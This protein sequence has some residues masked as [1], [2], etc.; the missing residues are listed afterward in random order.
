MTP[1]KPTF[2]GLS[3]ERRLEW[4]G[5]VSLGAIWWW[6]PAADHDLVPPLSAITR[7]LFRLTLD[8]VLM[9]D[10]LTSLGRVLPGVAIALLISTLLALITLRFKSLGFAIG[11]ILELLRPVP[12][13]AWIPIAILL[14]GIGNAPAIA[15]V[16]LGAFFPIWLGTQQGFR[17]VRAQ[18]ILT[19]RSFG[20]SRWVVLSDV[21]LPSMLP[22]CLH[23]LRLGLGL[24]WFSVVAA[25]MIGAQSGLGY[26]VQ[27]YSLNLELA[28]TYGYI[29]VIG[30]L[31]AAMSFLMRLIERRNGRWREHSLVEHE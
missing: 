22:Y 16:A 31:G 12:P 3:R 25:E 27:L 10:V 18:H 6:Y 29:L 14:L 28:K 21:V 19:A 13:I 4:L 23:G 5:I 1:S 7:E 26:G 15:I 2:L 20:A 11:G 9:R 30:A 17:E 24:G 8:G